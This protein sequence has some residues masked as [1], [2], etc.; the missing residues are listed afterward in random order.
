VVRATHEI[1]VIA[2]RNALPNMRFVPA[3]VRGRKVRQLV[4]EPFVFAIADST[5]L[6][7]SKS[8]QAA[9]QNRS[10]VRILEGVRVPAGGGTKVP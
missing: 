5:G 6:A 7:A 4:Q 9:R 3:E 8:P 2:V 1:F 10:G